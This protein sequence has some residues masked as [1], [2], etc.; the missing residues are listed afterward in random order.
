L[1]TLNLKKKEMNELSLKSNLCTDDY[2]SPCIVVL[3]IETESPILQMSG[4]DSTSEN[5]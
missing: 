1:Y 4:E 5:W 3:E 2:E